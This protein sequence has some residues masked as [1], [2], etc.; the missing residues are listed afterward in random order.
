MRWSI[1]R[2]SLL[3]QDIDGASAAG[4]ITC[5]WQSVKS[6]DMMQFQM[7]AAQLDVRLSFALYQVIW[8]G[9]CM[10]QGVHSP[11]EAASSCLCQGDPVNEYNV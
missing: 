11:R 9:W 1:P 4:Q 7:I 8:M 5:C 2:A 10:L 3:K 6:R